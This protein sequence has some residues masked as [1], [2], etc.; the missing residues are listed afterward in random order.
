MASYLRIALATFW[1]SGVGCAQVYPSGNS[2][3][4]MAMAASAPAAGA[5]PAQTSARTTS[6]AGFAD[7]GDLVVYP[8]RPT[9]RRDGVH[10]WHRAGLSEEHA[11]QAI[12]GVMKI[13]AP[14][15]RLLQFAYERHVEH[16]SGDW[17]WIGRARGAPQSEEVILTFGAR[18]AYGTIAQPGK[19][20][21]KLTTSDGVAWLIE[22]DPARIDRI[23]NERT[24]PGEP[25]FRV[26]PRLDAGSDPGP[27]PYPAFALSLPSFDGAAAATTVDLLLGYTAGFA[28]AHGGQP[29]ALTRLN[30]M[31][32]IAN[33]AFANSQLDAR[34]RLV[35]AMQVSYPDHTSNLSTLE[36]MT[37]FRWPST[38]TTPDLAFAALRSA[39]NQ[40]GADLVSLVRVGHNDGCGLAWLVGGNLAGIRSSDEYFGYSVVSDGYAGTPGAS[41]FCREETLAHE[42]GHNLGSQHD[43]A[44]ATL[45]GKLTYGAY[46]YSFGHKMHAGAGNFFT[47]MSYRDS[48]QTGYRIFSNPRSGFCGAPCGV[49]NVADNARSLG[50]TMPVVAT[51]RATVVPAEPEFDWELCDLKLPAG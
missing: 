10:T 29:Q 25:D 44:T 43:H 39:R 12:G 23:D 36:A 4:Q 42:L 9:T 32:E 48:G 8:A 6:V 21:L 15:G 51:F 28:A 45:D 22:T 3:Q 35:H 37:G 49:E 50:Q 38:K 31:V 18:A 47:V 7:R 13:S 14:D 16:P 34:I 30:N 19:A 27:D 41:Y 17:T 1:L 40:Y 11:L 26:P 24:R 46:P 2:D 5:R 33:Q 20:P